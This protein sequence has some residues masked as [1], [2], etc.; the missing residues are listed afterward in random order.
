MFASSRVFLDKNGVPFGFSVFSFPLVPCCFDFFL[1]KFSFFRALS[2]VEG[3]VVSSSIAWDAESALPFSWSHSFS[4]FWERAS[5]KVM[6]STTT[7]NAPFVTRARVA[8]VFGVELST[9]PTLRDGRVYFNFFG[10]MMEK[11][12]SN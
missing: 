9:F 12:V 10:V 2:V 4:F 7:F 8:G 6:I 3:G 5:K 1:D 11:N